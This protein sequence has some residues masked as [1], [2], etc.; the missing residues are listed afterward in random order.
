MDLEPEATTT[1]H[2]IPQNES[3]YETALKPDVEPEMMKQTFITMVAETLPTSIIEGLAMKVEP[4]PTTSA[5]QSS[6]GTIPELMTMVVELITAPSIRVETDKVGNEDLI[7]GVATDMHSNGTELASVTSLDHFIGAVAIFLTIIGIVGNALS[8]F[9]FWKRRRKTIHD[10]LYLVISV[11][12]ALTSAACFPVIVSLLNS[13]SEMLF[14]NVGICYSWPVIFYLLIRVSMFLVIFISVTRAIAIVKPLKRIVNLQ[15]KQMLLAVLSYS[16]LLITT[17]LTFLLTGNGLI[18]KEIRYIKEVSFC[19]IF[20]MSGQLEKDGH[21][22]SKWSTRLY[23]GILHLELILPCL[24]VL[25]SF[26]MS[27][28]ALTR[29]N[30]MHS[31]DEKRFRRVSVTIGLFTALFLICYLPC[32]VLQVIYFTS[33]FN[34]RLNFVGNNGFRQY[35]HLLIQMV[36]PLLNVAINPCLYLLRMPRYRTWITEVLY[37]YYYTMLY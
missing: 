18:K 12:D 24:L 14:N 20:T 26:I 31:E 33:L 25:S 13:R 29:R 35:G 19:E 32:F 34:V 1:F 15:P 27:T 17:D 22:Q 3:G 37:M 23:S 6:P 36:L 7:I 10:F 28:A 30:T 21:F 8:F 5:I 2:I 4:I 9:Y 16:V 11:V